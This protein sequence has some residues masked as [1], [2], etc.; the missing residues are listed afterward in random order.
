MFE[1]AYTAALRHYKVGAW[2]PAADIWLGAH[3]HLQFTSLQ[4]FW[5]GSLVLSLGKVEKQAE[6]HCK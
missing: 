1:A 6:W 2:Y 5:P 4:A 3:T